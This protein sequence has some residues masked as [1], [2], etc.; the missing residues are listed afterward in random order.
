M[1]QSE[2]SRPH[3]RI[4]VADDEPINLRILQKLLEHCGLT[5][6]VAHDGLECVQKAEEGQYDVVLMDINM[7]N[8]DGVAATREIARK[9]R[10]R[11]PKVIAVTA[12]ASAAQKSE[13]DA[14]G[15]SGFIPKPVRLS[16]LKK[17]LAT[18]LT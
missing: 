18:S 11:G 16:D 13:C 5:C 17:A 9:L 15:F 8:L 1:T 12:N 10:P 2:T 3:P 14:A 4:L 7:P 6:E